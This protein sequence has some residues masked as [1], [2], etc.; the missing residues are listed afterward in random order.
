MR[1]ST[2]FISQISATKIST[3]FDFRDVVKKEEV[4]VYHFIFKDSSDHYVRFYHG[5]LSHLAKGVAS[6]L[7]RLCLS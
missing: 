3:S 6:S 2:G 5:P 1:T 7:Y 4:D